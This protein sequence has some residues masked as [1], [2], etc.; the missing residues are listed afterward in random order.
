[1]APGA[2]AKPAIDSGG[3]GSTGSAR[4]SCDEAS[5]PRRLRPRAG[6]TSVFGSGLGSGLAFS[7][8]L[9]LAGGALPLATGLAFS[10]ALP[11]AGGAFFAAALL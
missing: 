8:A 2:G 5:V 4:L 9:P 11:L 10:A 7:T 1:M 3:V 6:L